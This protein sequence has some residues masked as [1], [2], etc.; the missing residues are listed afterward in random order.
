MGSLAAYILLSFCFLPLPTDQ[1]DQAL[2][3]AAQTVMGAGAM[4]LHASGDGDLTHPG[5][6]KVRWG[7][8]L[9]P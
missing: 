6:L 7:L 1:R 2:R 3:L 4:V 8:T 5:I 9:K